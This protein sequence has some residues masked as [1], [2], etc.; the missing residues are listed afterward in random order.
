MA[1]VP[2]GGNTS[3]SA[4]TAS[5]KKGLGAAVSHL[6]NREAEISLDDVSSAANEVPASRPAL[7][8]RMISLRVSIFPTL[9]GDAVV[10]RLMN[11]EDML[12]HIDQLGMVEGTLALFKRLIAK[13]YGMVLVTGP[14]GSGKTTTLYSLLQTMRAKEKNIVT[15]EDPV[16]LRLED[17]RQSQVSGEFTFAS[18]MRSILR[19]D[20]DVIMIGEIRDP[21]TAENAVR[22]SLAGRVVLSTIHA[23]TTLG[24]IPRMIDMHVDRSLIAYSLNG[25]VAQRLVRKICPDCRIGYT[26]HQEFL[27]YFKIDPAQQ[28]FTKGAGC[29]ACRHTGFRGRTGLFEVLYFDDT[30]QTLIIERAPMKELEDYVAKSGIKTLKQDAMEKALAGITTL[31]EAGKVV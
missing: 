28:T 16:E 9:A 26:P 5:G 10:L 25:V 4:P 31:E 12:L 20:P 17:I 23:N 19:Q 29:E 30:V 2:E 15:L 3:E 27:A 8:P 7:T 6:F 11:R 14:S 21:E 13:D 18:G 24:T 1:V 22:A